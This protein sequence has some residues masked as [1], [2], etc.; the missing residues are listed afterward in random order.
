MGAA[1]GSRGQAPTTQG[2]G[3]KIV[4]SY[5]DNLKVMTG[6]RKIGRATAGLKQN[7]FFLE[8]L[9][10]LAFVRSG[11]V[12]TNDGKVYNVGNN[13]YGWSRTAKSTTNAYNL[14]VNPSEVYPSSDNNRWNGFPLRWILAR[15]VP[16]FLETPPEW[17]VSTF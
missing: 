14:G 4:K 16:I 7:D 1:G 17:G 9:P 10:G 6:G 3:R 8:R 2:F 11:N 5:S 15:T 13:L 12:N